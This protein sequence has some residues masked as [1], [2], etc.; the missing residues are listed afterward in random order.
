MIMRDDVIRGRIDETGPMR[1]GRRPLNHEQ[2]GAG[3]S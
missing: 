3:S 2:M 1:R